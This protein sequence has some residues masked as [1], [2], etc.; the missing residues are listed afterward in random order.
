MRRY[1]VVLAAALALLVAGGAG[2]SGTIL[3][4]EVPPAETGDDDPALTLPATP[5]EADG[6]AAGSVEGSDVRAA[7]VGL[8]MTAAQTDAIA[9]LAT[10]RPG[11]AVR[12]NR[13]F[14][15][16]STVLRHGAALSD[17][18]SDAPDAAARAWLRE[19]AALFGW[20]AGAVDGLRVAKVLSQP[21][22][23]AVSVLFHQVFDGVEAGGMGGSLVASLDRDNRV[24]LVRAD[25]VRL[26]R[27]AEAPRLS[28]G[29]AFRQ[30]TGLVAPVVVGPR[31]GWTELARGSLAG[32]HFARSTVLAE[33]DG[34]ARP[35]WELRIARALDD[36]E[37]VVVD[38]VTGAVLLRRQA[39]LH[40]EADI[41]ENHPGAEASPDQVRVQMPE[42]WVG[43][44]PTTAGNNASTATNWGVFIA[45]DGPGQLRPLGSFTHPFTDA[46][47]ASNCGENPLGAELGFLDA[48]TYAEDA[49]PAVVNLFYHHNVAHDLWYDL[50]FDEEAG[51]MQLD[52]GEHGGE[53]GDPL[54]GLV[55]AGAAAGDVPPLYPGRDNA[56]MFPN[57]D[58]I[59]QWSGMFLWEPIP[60]TFE[61]PCTDGDFD[62]S[63]IYH[64]Y[65]HGVT[66]RWVGAEFGNLDSYQGGSMGEAWGDVFAIHDLMSRRL[67][68]DTV[69]GRYVTGNDKSGIRN[70]ALADVPVGFGDLGYDLTGEEVHADGEI[71]NGVLWDI[72][73]AIAPELAA[74]LIADAMPISG[75][76][77]SMVDMRDAILTAD[78]ARTGGTNQDV[79]WQVFAVRGL[80][81]S[82]SS[83]DAD[84]INPRP[85][86]NHASPQRNGRLRGVVVDRTSGKPVAGAR[87]IV[88]RYEARVSDAATTS[89]GGRFE[90][91]MLQGA[92]PITIQA[93][94]YGSR[95]LTVTVGKDRR[96]QRF[97]LGANLASSAA[98]ATAEAVNGSV[99]GD[100][101]LAIDDTE[102]TT[103][104]TDPDED[105]PTKEPI[106]ID[107]AGDEPVTISRLRISAMTAPG[108]PRFEAL[109][110]FEAS[111]SLDGI[112]W[113]PVASGAFKTS[114]PRPKAPDLH[115]RTWELATPAEARY[116]RV[117]ASPQ[118]E[119][120]DGVQIAE[121]QAFGAGDDVVISPEAA[122]ADEPFSDQGTALLPT[123][124]GTATYTLMQQVCVAPPPTQGIDAWVTEL[125][126]GFG[127]ANHI[128][129]V[130]AE[131]IAADPRPDVDLYF[132][133]ADCRPTGSIATTAPQEV[134]LIPQGT[135]YVVSQLYT[136][137]PA[138][139]FLEARQV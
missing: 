9:R 83:V 113:T 71:W 88:G 25:V 58:G 111:T 29:E 35:V 82:A 131:P 13:S 79:L 87:I 12:W 20:E 98:G 40:D 43:P 52:N 99:L 77:P 11:T 123:A 84:D 1:G 18:R 92:W 8:G 73:E 90:L 74:Q 2:S 37:R 14:G 114:G 46:W 115:Y 44:I 137:A 47:R 49:L 127:D 86:F 27:L 120:M 94:G 28:I 107:L 132:L 32:P 48:P 30:A 135:K 105:G 119:V 139:I 26:P 118:S 104:R 69:V 126:D 67:Q 110:D 81:V 125:P 112:R 54:L 31:A 75:P 130:R 108:T 63:V 53:P 70:W 39:V 129:E 6:V 22:N 56:Y 78:L 103:W 138:T 64:E 133:S 59:P 4:G 36:G 19:H 136:T 24:L 16:P 62:A 50:G 60:Q 66:S 23:G 61:V 89:A 121:I 109:R 76:M 3:P 116:L 15:T 117:V 38:A 80:G 45:P 100:P 51:A 106:V 68:S 17:A 42:E 122:Q 41:F 97:T 72:R 91:P 55:Q 102:R 124:D 34:V 7:T 95:T 101:E 128:I 65:A 10:E 96:L 21:G 134:G 93:P 5:L 57:P 33:G 85:A